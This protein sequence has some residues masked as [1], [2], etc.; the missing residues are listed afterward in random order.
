MGV[1]RSDA[2]RAC[3]MHEETWKPGQ[4]N[5]AQA[6]ARALCEHFPWVSIWLQVPSFPQVPLPVCCA[7]PT[8]SMV[9]WEDSFFPVGLPSTFVPMGSEVLRYIR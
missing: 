7:T 6:L 4:A 8:P 2:L 5:V 3:Q 9:C 1:P